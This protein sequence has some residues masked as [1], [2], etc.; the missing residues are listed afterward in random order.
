MK[1][2]KENLAKMEAI[3]LKHVKV[4]DSFWNPW[5]E[6]SKRNDYSLSMGCSK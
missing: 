5:G 6:I 2:K 1:T 4:N 3:G